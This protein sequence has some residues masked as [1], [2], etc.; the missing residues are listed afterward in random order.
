MD[1]HLRASTIF[2]QVSVV[3]PFTASR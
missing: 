1:R 3:S 2:R